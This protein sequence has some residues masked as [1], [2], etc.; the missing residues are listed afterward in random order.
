VFKNVGKELGV[1]AIVAARAAVGIFWLRKVI[2]TL[3][4]D[5]SKRKFGIFFDKEGN[6][7]IL[8]DLWTFTEDANRILKNLDKPPSLDSPISGEGQGLEGILKLLED[9][10]QIVAKTLKDSKTK[11][12]LLDEEYSK[13]ASIQAALRKEKDLAGDLLKIYN[14][15]GERMIKIKAEQKRLETTDIWGNMKYG[16]TDYANSVMDRNKQIQDA[17][18]SGMKTV[19]DYLSKMVVD[20]EAKWGA[21]RDAILSDL[22]HIAIRQQITGPLASWMGGGISGTPQTNPAVINTPSATPTARGRRSARGRVGDST[23]NLSN[24]IQ[25]IVAENT[26]LMNR[27]VDEFVKNSE[28][29]FRRLGRTLK[30]S[31]NADE[32]GKGG[33]LG[34][35][36]GYSY[37]GMGGV[38]G[39]SAT[40]GTAV[41]AG[42]IDIGMGQ[43]PAGQA[44]TNLI[45]D[46]S[47]KNALDALI[48]TN[49]I[50]IAT[51]VVT[52]VLDDVTGGQT[53]NIF[54]PSKWSF[55]GV[56]GA[57][58]G[59]TIINVPVSI[60]GGN[61]A[62]ASEMRTEIEKTVIEVMRRYA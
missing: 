30:R 62:M 43:H 22:A 11:V 2:G 34:S 50:K 40:S 7:K 17:M 54:N 57:S 41:S 39:G 32:F 61:S 55:R 19:E 23:V 29:Q 31:L 59:N 46:P 14:A 35:P 8:D 24:D 16:F 52:D 9:N 49:V 58:G 47:G 26:F 60:E 3:I 53:K 33:V 37:P 38:T 51:D 27:D 1:L 48:E 10:R 12:E 56:G 6:K 4:T 25:N 36:T 18:I 21:F 45:N 20:G 5:L 13:L 15:L 42:G 44:I 28:T